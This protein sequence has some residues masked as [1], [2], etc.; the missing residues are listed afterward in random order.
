[1]ARR[2]FRRK[3][4]RP[5]KG[6]RVKRKFTK[7]R[8]NRYT[9]QFPKVQTVK[10]V[11]TETFT[12]QASSENTP[13]TRF[14]RANSAYDPNPIT[15]IGQWTAMGYNRYS[16][17]YNKVLVVG[18]KMDLNVISVTQPHNDDIPFS[19]AFSV[20]TRV[21]DDLSQTRYLTAVLA[22]PGTHS[23]VVPG[24]N[25][26]T[27]RMSHK[28]GMRKAFGRSAPISDLQSDVNNN[29]P[30]QQYFEVGM[31]ALAPVTGFSVF[32]FIV[33]IAYLCRFTSLKEVNFDIV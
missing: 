23:V 18:S 11:Y 4:R 1:M 33:R 5:F 12:L 14:F 20:Y 29:P 7:R 13:V 2:R 30:M 25:S 31:A 15:G 10:L 16:S 22:N 21:D 26:R 27:L 24:D 3:T 8:R 32:T 17:L 19:G 28:W 9:R 6:R